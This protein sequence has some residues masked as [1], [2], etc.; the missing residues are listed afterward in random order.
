V[1]VSE[2]IPAVDGMVWVPGGTFVML[3]RSRSWTA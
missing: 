3:E 1:A 2:T